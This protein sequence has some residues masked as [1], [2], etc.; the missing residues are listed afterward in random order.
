MWGHEIKINILNERRFV[1]HFFKFT[2]IFIFIKGN[3][4]A[5]TIANIVPKYSKAF[6]TE[7][8]IFAI[9][10]C[11]SDSRYNANLVKHSLIIHKILVFFFNVSFELCNFTVQNER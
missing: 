7:L 6:I 8:I 11:R 3:P 5:E 9:F 1:K 4:P 10:K 2:L